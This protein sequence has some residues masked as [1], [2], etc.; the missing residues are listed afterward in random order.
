MNPDRFTNAQIV[1]PDR[2]VE[3]G[4]IA[5][6]NGY[7]EKIDHTPNTGIDLQG[8][9]IFPGLI[10]L[11]V[12]GGGNHLFNHVYDVSS[13]NALLEANLSTGTTG[14]LATLMLDHTNI[15]EVQT[16]FLANQKTELGSRLLG[17][18]VEG[19][20]FNP[21]KAAMHDSA[22]IIKPD[23]EWTEKLLK[24]GQGRIKI[25]TLAP[26]MQDADKVIA[27][28]NK[29][30]VIASVAHS[31]ATE[32]EMCK[33]LQDGITMATHLFNTMSPLHHHPDNAGMVPV[34]LN[35]NAALGIIADGMH[36]N[37][38]M[39]SIVLKMNG[40]RPFFVS[41][42]I[43]PLGTDTKDFI[44]RGENIK[45]VK[46][47]CYNTN[48]KMAAS[49]TPLFKGVINAHRLGF[50]LFDMV[51]MASLF[52]AQLIGFDQNY[53]SIEAGKCADFLIVDKKT[54]QLKA[55]YKN[56]IKF[57]SVYNI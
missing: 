44:Y 25:M 23:V 31:Y 2:I 56:G 37:D 16:K 14:L 41:D 52:P 27:C 1:L 17:L 33:G 15:L 29:N 42:A 13:L 39:L 26:E 57:H 34:L 12:N 22:L 3:Q 10:D 20:F 4:S 46:G 38:Y 49:I 28:L 47:A 54:L 30:N 24:A 45:V 40:T 55:V 21:I 18:H 8:D 48:G 36:V 51:R 6:K 19:P 53:G 43:S 7:F 32:Q 50:E 5:V 9:Y 35:S 11:Q